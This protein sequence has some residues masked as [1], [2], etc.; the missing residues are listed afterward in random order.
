MPSAEKTIKSAVIFY[1][2]SKPEAVRMMR[3]VR[4]LLKQKGLRVWVEDKLAQRA[5]ATGA[6]LEK[7]RLTDIAVALGG[8]GTMLQAARRLAPLS[9]PLLGIN[10]GG[11]GFLSGTDAGDFKRVCDSVLRGEFILEERRMIRVEA[12]RGGRRLFGPNIALNDCVIR[13]GDQARAILLR[14]RSGER[15]E[16]GRAHV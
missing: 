11:L 9:I 7:L 12:F 15:F 3:V 4:S 2:E 5:A 1:N 8:D 6:V 14:A 16:I 13:C 10:S